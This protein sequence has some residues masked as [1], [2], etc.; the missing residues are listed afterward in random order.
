M[1]FAE[2]TVRPTL[3]GLSPGHLHEHF[4]ASRG[5]Q[6]I[7]QGEPDDDLE[8]AEQYLLLGSRDLV[9][10]RLRTLVDLL[11]WVHPDVLYV[12]LKI[13]DAAEYRETVIADSFGKFVAFRRS[14]GGP[15]SGVV[16]A[17]LTRDPEIARH[18]RSAVDLS[19]AW[20]ELRN[21]TR[22][23][24]RE[25]ASVTGRAY[26]LTDDA[27]SARFVRDLVQVWGRPVSTVPNIRRITPN[28]WAHDAA[29]VPAGVRFIGP[30]WIGAGRTLDAGSVVGPAALWDDP[31]ARPMSR[32]VTWDAIEPSP[33]TSDRREV[34]VRRSS[35]LNRY[36]K[37]MFDIVFSVAV[38]IITFP[39]WL[40]VMAAIW[41]ED[42]RPL[43]FVQ[44][45][46]TLGGRE[47]PCIKFR[48]MRKDADTLKNQLATQNA[49]DGPQFFI[50]K[51]PRLTRVGQLIRRCN[52]DELPQFLNV[53]G[54][55]MSVVG[56]RPSPHNENQFCPR[57]REARLS[58]PAGI[59]GLWQV[60]RTRR[61]GLDFQEWIKYDIEYAETVNWRLDLK[62]IWRTFGV[63]ISGVIQP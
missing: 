20:R 60:S 38:L 62:I 47:F 35:T 21:A 30:V 8:D 6:V 27:S 10:F 31:A 53:L 50:K 56:P 9:L 57:W 7:R 55:E 54:G 37:R 14:Y 3:W 5:V 19:T 15:E 44:R 4:W 2:A 42:G 13:A 23:G 48:S 51:D 52:V 22:R 46:E 41:L 39:L 45:R 28:V 63:L 18:W 29:R 61:R 36:S 43:F 34:P 11:S 40:V 26:D 24:R 12:R 16:R 33:M 25:V 58:V 17:A 49:A 32:A 59:T 1:S